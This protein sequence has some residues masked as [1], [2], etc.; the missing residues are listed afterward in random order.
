M[1]AANQT[2]IEEEG[3]LAEHLQSCSSCREALQQY[4]QI[5]MQTFAEAATREG[6]ANPFQTENIEAAEHR[7]AKERLLRETRR[8][9]P[10][11]LTQDS[12]TRRPAGNGFIPLKLSPLGM[13]SWAIRY[14]PPVQQPNVMTVDTSQFEKQIAEL[15]QELAK[16]QTDREKSLAEVQSQSVGE[17]Q[18]LRTE[19]ESLRQDLTKSES[20]RSREAGD[21]AAL[22]D[23]LRLM[24]SSLDI[25]QASNASLKTE[26][27]DIFQKV[28]NLTAD[29]RQSQEA[30]AR[31]NARNVKL[32][33]E[34]LSQVRFV[35]RQQKLLAT[36]HDLRDILGARSLRIIDV[37]D[38]GSKGEFEQPFG[39]IFYTEGKSLIFY[40][41]DLDR[42]KGLKPG[43]IF[44]A[45]GQKGEGKDIPHSLGAFYMDDPAQNRWILK[46]DDAKLLS[47]VDYVFVT[48]SSH[49]EGV[50]PRGKPLLSASL[51]TNANHTLR[52]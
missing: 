31:I 45:W 41:F 25:L 43:V 52:P 27:E 5:V 38:V 23:R 42:Q 44:Q 18:K 46:V 10:L 13:P 2:S 19:I 20:A 4:K 15:R 39:R 17:T 26:K 50:K 47:R 30:M 33:Q 49:K 14:G 35:E 22:Q 34:S 21:Y 8:V 6:E 29:L 24:Q 37:Y 16:V 9:M 7:A 48:D 32:E 11:P 51:N 1:A 12:P 36:D 28:S 3:L 40:A